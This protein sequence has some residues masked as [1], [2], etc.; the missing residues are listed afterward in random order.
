MATFLEY[1]KL[2]KNIFYKWKNFTFDGAIDN[3]VISS[4]ANT[5]VM[6]QQIGKYFTMSYGEETLFA[7]NISVYN[8]NESQTK[9]MFTGRAQLRTDNSTDADIDYDV[10][11]K[12]FP[13]REIKLSGIATYNND[14]WITLLKDSIDYTLGKNIDFDNESLIPVVSNISLDISP[15]QATWSIT[16][17]AFG[18]DYDNL[19][20]SGSDELDVILTSEENVETRI[21]KWYDVLIV[22][23]TSIFPNFPIPNSSDEIECYVNS[24]NISWDIENKIYFTIEKNGTIKDLPYYLPTRLKTGLNFSGYSPLVTDK[25]SESYYK[26]FKDNKLNPIEDVVSEKFFMTDRQKND[27]AIKIYIANQGGV[28][29]DNRRIDKRIGEVSIDGASTENAFWLIHNSSFSL[30]PGDPMEVTIDATKIFS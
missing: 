21:V 17:K 8:S 19:F 15:Q 26:V 22:F 24:I 6:H 16:W 20:S 9:A 29:N 23:D 2:I 7:E 5:G 27:D 3:Q 14:A 1:N 4:F 25:N 28:I 12:Q 11:N 18:E 10:F 13:S 30:S